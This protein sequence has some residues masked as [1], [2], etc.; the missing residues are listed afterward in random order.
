MRA[1]LRTYHAIPSLQAYQDANTYKQLQDAP[2]L[3]S[4]LKG[5]CEDREEPTGLDKIREV[6]VPPRTNP[7]NLIFVICS[8][9]YKIADLHFPPGQEFHD[10]VMKTNYSSDSRARAFLWLMWFY[11]ESDFTQEG[12]EENPF[13]PGVDYGQDVANQGVPQLVVMTPEDEAAENV[14]TEG[15]KQFGRDKQAMRARILEADQQFIADRDTKRAR[16]RP[17]AFAD[18]APA[19]LPRIRPSKHE[20]DMDSTRSTPPPRGGPPVGRGS[21]R[22][23]GGGGQTTASAVA[24]ALAPGSR[25]NG[26]SLKWAA[27]AAVTAA[28]AP[29]PPV[30]PNGH[31]GQIVD[32]LVARKPRPPTAHQLAVERNRAQRV[33]HIINCEMR[34]Q[35]KESLRAR[36]TE[37]AILRA[38][39]RLAYGESDDVLFDSEADEDMDDDGGGGGGG[40]SGGGANGTAAGGTRA[41]AARKRPAPGFRERGLGGLSTRLD[42]PDDFGEEPAAYAAALRRAT[43]R[44]SRW[45]TVALD[46]TAPPLG[47]VQPRKKRRVEEDVE[48]E[49]PGVPPFDD[50]EGMEDAEDDG[51]EVE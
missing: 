35:H 32:G 46:R 40:G 50:D 42:E 49:Q 24:A 12:C 41:R 7:V 20:S 17:A 34:R 8:A 11:L 22:E 45:E 25:R 21:A 19:I 47:V 48:D 13:G 33:E 16:A 31:R 28:T 43:R 18:D 44:M 36:R 26:N 10:L 29:S 9:A 6:E 51:S 37:G 27:A 4:I 1:Q 3:K 39:R 2:R 38:S 30:E 5:G 14:D 23:A 15:E